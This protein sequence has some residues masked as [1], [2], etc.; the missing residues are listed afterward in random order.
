MLLR[1]N[2]N[3]YG[4]LPESKGLQQLRS[5]RVPGTIYVKPGEFKGDMFRP[6]FEALQTGLKIYCVLY[7]RSIWIYGSYYG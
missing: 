2:R 1:V 3:A 7:P 4:Q 6:F 5:I